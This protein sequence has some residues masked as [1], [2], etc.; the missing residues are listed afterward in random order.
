MSWGL[1]AA[2]RCAAIICLTFLVA[3]PTAAASGT[4]RRILSVAEQKL[5]YH[6]YGH[7]CTK[8]GPCE[9]WCA[10]FLTWVWERAG[11]QIPSLAFTGYLYDWARSSTRVL[12][13]RGVPEPGDAVLFGTGPATVS[14][15]LHTGVVEG[16]YPGYLVTIEGD[17]LHAVRRFVVP[18]RDPQ[19][20][21]EPGPIYAYAS[22]VAAGGERRLS[23]RSAAVSSFPGVP[24]AL[25][26]RQDL[27]A[28]GSPQRRRLLHAIAALRA[29]QH[30]PYRTGQVLIN[31][32]GVD[33][34]GL[35][36]VRVTSSM[37]LS[38][39]RSAWRSFLRRFN[40]AGYA[41]TVS[42]QA[43]P[44]PPIGSAQPSITAARR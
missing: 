42:F 10:L 30:M 5:G 35:V 37:P 24:S 13:P 18:L 26:A 27:V 1:G 8:F 39:A 14:T 29:F 44:D 41:Y 21:G 23:S 19:L 25:I 22:P 31:W 28:R 15:S 12:G 7:F 20:V 36:E 2:A 3:A 32:T 6:D 4:R 9:E 11:V 40:D 38:F 33:S 16:V 43:P 34:R 17:S